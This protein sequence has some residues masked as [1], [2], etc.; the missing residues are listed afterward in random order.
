MT[1]SSA[2]REVYYAPTPVQCRCALVLRKLEDDKDNR[3]Q[4]H[5]STCSYMVMVQDD[6]CIP[7]TWRRGMHQYLCA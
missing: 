3:T 4:N 5:Q 2:G 6:G 1:G 7:T